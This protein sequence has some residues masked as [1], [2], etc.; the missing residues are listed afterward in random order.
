MVSLAFSPTR[1]I[2]RPSRVAHAH[3]LCRSFEPHPVLQTDF[4]TVCR[5]SPM[6]IQVQRSYFQALGAERFFFFPLSS[7]YFL[8]DEL[9]YSNFELRLLLRIAAPITAPLLSLFPLS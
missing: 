7:L 1:P 3:I 2:S 9:R 8:C 5:D 6:S 4:P